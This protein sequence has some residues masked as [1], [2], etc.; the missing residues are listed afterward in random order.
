MPK[1]KRSSSLGLMEREQSDSAAKAP[2]APPPATAGRV[3][4]AVLSALVVLALWAFPAVWYVKREPGGKFFWLQGQKQVQGWRYRELAVDASAEKVLVADELVCGEFGRSDAEVVRVF[5]A[6]RFD[7]RQNEIGLFVHTPDRCWTEA[8]WKIEPVAPDV[9]DLDVHG[10]KLRAERRLFQKQGQRELVYF[11]GLV[12]GQP[13]PYRLDHNLSVG[14]RYALQESSGSE[15]RG[16]GLR[17]SDSKLWTRVWESF[18]TRRPLLGPKQF[19]RISTP[20]TH[21]DIPGGDR[22]LR[23]VLPLWLKLVAYEQAVKEWQS[24][25]EKEPPAG[26]KEESGDQKTDGR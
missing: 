16:A 3:R 2:A 10:V 24:A 12:G 20:V 18:A 25:K 14:M 23:E 11:C 21:T 26:T 19:L 8:G 17:A 5:A 22:R 1:V 7:P 4:L 6:S 13:L 9:V 15:G